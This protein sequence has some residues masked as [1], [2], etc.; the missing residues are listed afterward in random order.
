MYIPFYKQQ[1]LFT[2]TLACLRMVLEAVGKKVTE[3]EL[4]KII[5]FDIRIGY[6][7]PMLSTMLDIMNIDH[8]LKRDANIEELKASLDHFYPIVVL[9]VKAY[10]NIPQNHG[11]M[12]VIKDITDKHII[13]N[14]P[15]QEFGGEDKEIDLNLFIRAWNESRNWMLVVK[16]EGK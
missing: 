6:S 11:H 15:D 5:G 7:M 4:S 9:S 1:T 2:C 13:F 10:Q 3:Y 12:V 8:D 16:G 14:D